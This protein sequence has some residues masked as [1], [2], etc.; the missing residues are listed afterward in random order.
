MNE[1]DPPAHSIHASLPWFSRIVLMGAIFVAVLLVMG[2]VP[3]CECG[4]VRLWHGAVMSSQNSQHISDW[5]SFSHIIHGFLFYSLV[6]F[7]ERM[8]GGA[9][10][11]GAKLALALLPEMGWEILENTDY[12]I[13]RYREA[14]I[15]LDYYGDSVLNS[16]ADVG[17]CALGFILASRLPLAATIALAVAFELFVGWQIRDNLTLNVIML[18]YPLDVIQQW[19]TAR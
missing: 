2:R 15:S 10:A 12:V 9:F 5:Y 16:A 19:Q 4:T 8:S 13:N 1:T 6:T 18:V 3:I 17:F 11:P 14:T 7:L